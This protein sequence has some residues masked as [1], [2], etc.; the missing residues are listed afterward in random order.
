MTLTETPTV[1]QSQSFSLHLFFCFFSLLWVILHSILLKIDKPVLQLIKEGGLVR[2][3]FSDFLLLVIFRF[4]PSM[5]T[6]RKTFFNCCTVAF[7]F[8]EPVLL[9]RTIFSFLRT[10][11]VSQNCFLPFLESFSFRSVPFSFFLLQSLFF[12]SF[13]SVQGHFRSAFDFFLK[14]SYY[15]FDHRFLEQV[16]CL[17]RVFCIGKFV[18]FYRVFVKERLARERD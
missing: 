8:S 16:L 4:F 11:F 1:L 9:F 3:L 15:S 7:C 10:G 2:R 12:R 13:L 6:E 17:F 5:P 18:E 14:K